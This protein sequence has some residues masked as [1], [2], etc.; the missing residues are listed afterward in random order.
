VTLPVDPEPRH[1]RPA[2]TAEA[3]A[4]ARLLARAFGADPIDRWCL[5]CDD[6]D[7]VLELECR[8]VAAQ[9]TAQGWFWVVD[10]LS[11]AAAWL[12]PGADYDDAALDAVVDPVLAEHG[13]S[14]ARQGRFWEWVDDHRPSTPHWYL[15]LVAASPE[16]R[17]TGIGHLL[18]THGLA[19]VDAL[20]DP[21]FL[22][23]GTPPLV[24]W[25][26][27]H[28]FVV[29]A[30]ELAP[31]GGPRVWFMVRPPGR[32]RR[33]RGTSGAGGHST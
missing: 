19:R 2:T 4:V 8:E 17:R 11:G 22:V 7:G 9:L 33:T 6:F 16:R 14:P 12:P 26:G 29:S 30:E 3:E 5:A 25:Y 23:T 20:G 27:R 18:L 13:G 32:P 24:P 15:D 31:D 28:G 21:S 10:D 1:V